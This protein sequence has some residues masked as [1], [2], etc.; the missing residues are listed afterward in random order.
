MESTE[1]SN[2]AKQ[3]NNTPANSAELYV[4]RTGP[5]APK[6]KKD[7]ILNGECLG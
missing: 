1:K 6:S 4:Y 7:I 5:T 2:Q 3:F